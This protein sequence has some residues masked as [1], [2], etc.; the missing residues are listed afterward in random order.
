MWRKLMFI[1][2]NNIE[3]RVYWRIIRKFFK[4]KERKIIVIREVYMYSKYFYLFKL[5]YL[6]LLFLK[7]LGI[8]IMYM[9]RIIFNLM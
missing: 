8:S 1:K 5:I 7:Y 3:W 2:I 6:F 4:Y 9:Y